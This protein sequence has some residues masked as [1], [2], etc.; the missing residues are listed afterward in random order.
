MLSNIVRATA[1]ASPFAAKFDDFGWFADRVLWL[2]PSQSEQ[3]KGLMVRM[4]NAFPGCHP[5]GGSFD[6]LIPHVTIGESGEMHLLR[7][8]MEAIRPHL[9]ITVNVTSLSLMAGSTE[10]ASWQVIERVALK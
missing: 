4:M 1:G 2:A 10:P 5:Y 7:A 9:P 6:E 3:F 8:A